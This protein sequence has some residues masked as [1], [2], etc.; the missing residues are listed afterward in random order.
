VPQ[1]ALRNARFELP[2]R[3][4]LGRPRPSVD[5]MLVAAGTTEGLRRAE[6]TLAEGLVAAGASVVV[7]RSRYRVARRLWRWVGR[8]LALIDLFEAA[9]LRRAATRA[10]LRY[11]PRATIYA[12]THAAMLQ[13]RSRTSR[14][15]A[16]RFDAPAAL[17]RRGRVFRVEHRLE[18]RRFARARFLLPFGVEPPPALAGLVP[19][20]PAV[21]ALPV[22]V[23]PTPATGLPREPLAVAY[24]GNPA[25]KGLDLVVQAW[26]LAGSRRLRLVLCGLDPETG[27]GWLARRGIPEPPGVQWRGRLDYPEYRRLVA[28]SEVLLAASRFEDHGLAQLEALVDGTLLVTVPS[29]G[30]YAALPLARGLDDRLVAADVSAPALAAA[31]RAADALR[32]AER[33]RYGERA[34]RLAGGHSAL[35]LRERLASEVLP[36]LLADGAGA[37]DGEPRGGR[38]GR[39]S[40]RSRR[41]AR[42]ERVGSAALP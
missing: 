34:R 8:H 6:A 18:R 37:G 7:V 15:Y 20:G 11:D 14:P 41:G 39:G 2:S 33:D 21:V 13:P 24:V 12:T 19:P 32:P 29:A 38:A 3:L 5:V 40:A 31:I 22:P 9:A 25:K 10:L 28:S 42:P 35:A 1:V 30:P 4:L 26:A 16:V 17:N 23:E 27:R 36:G